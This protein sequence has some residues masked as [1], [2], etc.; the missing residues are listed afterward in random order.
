MDNKPNTNT[1]KK[2]TIKDRKKAQP[3]AIG[4]LSDAERQTIRTTVAKNLTDP[5]YSVF[6][7]TCQ[8]LGL[9]PLLNEITAISY[10]GNMSIQV[11]RDGFLTIAHKSGKFAGLESG[12]KLNE[13]KNTIGWARVYHK[14]FTV[15]VY[16]EA[17]MSEYSTGKNLWASKPHTMIKKVAESMALRKAFNVN[18]VY[19]QKEME[20][21]IMFK[22]PPKIK[23][24][25]P[26]ATISQVATL[27]ALGVEKTPKTK[28]EAV[29]LIKTATKK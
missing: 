26:P 1:G 20:K 11:M 2:I 21:K 29:E 19:A 6:I 9:N 24:P 13:S 18:G 8:A 22:K 25:E 3:G 17:E 23:D 4:F 7:Y 14:D 28:L 10:A 16:Q 15:P 27:K 12:T 5:Q